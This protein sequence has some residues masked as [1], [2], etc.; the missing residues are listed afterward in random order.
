MQGQRQA[1]RLRVCRLTRKPAGR[2]ERERPEDG[3]SP[4]PR[5]YARVRPAIPRR[6]L[7][8]QGRAEQ[9][10]QGR[11]PS[12]RSVTLRSAAAIRI[13]REKG[14]AGVWGS[15]CIQTNPPSLFMIGSAIRLALSEAKKAMMVATSSADAVN[16]P[17]PP[18]PWRRG[19]DRF[20][21]AGGHAFQ[22]IAARRKSHHRACPRDDRA[23]IL[24]AIGRGLNDV[25]GADRS[26]IDLFA[27]PW[28][29][30]EANGPSAC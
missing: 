5:P 19:T 9:R 7:R 1:Q 12:G 20:R 24:G 8:G 28:V 3:H 13:L 25:E 30:S 16:A 22:P 4:Q 14:E 11:G 21:A 6:G 10:K 18:C 27:H 17:A 29:G 23:A 15:A 2:D 26:R